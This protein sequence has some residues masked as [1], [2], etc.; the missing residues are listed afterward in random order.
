ML[1]LGGRRAGRAR[2]PARRRLR[3]SARQRDLGGRLGVRVRRLPD[4]PAAGLRRRPR[5]VAARCAARAGRD[6][7]ALGRPPACG[8]PAGPGR[9]ALLAIPGLLLVAGTL[10]YT[11]AADHGQLSIVSVLGSLFPVF[12]V[13]A[14]RDPARRAPLARAGDRASSRAAR[15]RPDRR[16][17]AGYDALRSPADGAPKHQ[18]PGTEGDLRRPARRRGGAR[19]RSPTRPRRVLGGAGYGR[20]E[21]P[22]FEDTGLFERGVGE[23]TDIVRKEMFTFEDQG[24]RSITLRPEGTAPICRAYVEHG[25]HKLPQPV[26]L[27]YQGPYFRYERPQEGRFRQ[28]N[29]I[30]AEAIGSDSP[31]VDA[32]LIVLL[33]R[34]LRD[35]G[36]ADLELRLSSLGSSE[37]RARLPRRAAR[38]TCASHEGRALR[39]GPRPDRL[40][41]DAGLRLRR[42]G[43]PRG[44]GGRTADARPARGRRRRALRR[45]PLAARRR[46]RRLRRSTAR[47]SAA[48]TT[49]TAPSS[50]STCDRL[51]AQSG[52]GG[53]GRYDGLV[54]LLGGP[55][56]S[57]RRL[58]RRDRA[59]PARDGGRR[60]EP[61][62]IDVF[63]VAGRG[64]R[65]R[66]FALVGELR[67][68]RARR[69]PRP[70]RAQLQGADE[71]GRPLR[72]SLT[73]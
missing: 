19:P 54:E 10:L 24:G 18:A 65:A 33:D 21:T 69:R 35:L 12:T 49:T 9:A 39:R 31:L 5:L 20:I 48:S 27:W 45:G 46:R 52:V 42:R 25:M 1:A 3:G 41:P 8:D 60:R 47:S 11:V 50:S 16:L 14:G 59:D 32:E 72:R 7:A 56:D 70:R 2:H 13:G 66:A 53:G 61:R 23:S 29:Q 63:V 67:G 37:A 40:Q 34:I 71:A 17:I 28:F 4:R 22:V 30:G 6:P 64:P 43:H 57:R 15:H 38:A 58:G 26:K 73:R 55:A 36:I 62:A 44:D 51:G 68:G